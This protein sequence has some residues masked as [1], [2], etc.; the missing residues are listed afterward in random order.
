[1]QIM[2]A[3]KID[4]AS[5]YRIFAQ[6][7]VPMVKPCIMTLTLFGFRDVWRHYLTEPYLMNR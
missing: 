5:P 3:A 7:I 6:I 4:G 2:E 1:M